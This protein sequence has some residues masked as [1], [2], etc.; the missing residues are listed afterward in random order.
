MADPKRYAIKDAA[1]IVLT[2][3][4]GTPETDG[5]KINYLN[6]FNMSSTSEELAARAKGVNLI[7]LYSAKE[8]EF[9]LDSEVLTKETMALMVGGTYD[10]ESDKIT[11]TGTTKPQYF[12][13]TGSFTMVSEDGEEEV[14]DLEAKK[15]ITVV[16]TEWGM[17]A[18][19]ISTF[20]Q[21]LKVMQD[22]D[23]NMFTIA[24]H[25]A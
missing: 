11:V 3:I 4:G 5:I 2:P 15:V 6:T 23:G 25:T 10:K 24:K 16:E 20:S 17:D 7:V 19:A 21:R 1:D 18:T 12:S 8:I 14:M 22:S 9:T 13:M